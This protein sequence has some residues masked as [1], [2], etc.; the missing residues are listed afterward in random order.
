MD[1]LVPIL[2]DRFQI[3]IGAAVIEIIVPHIEFD[4]RSSQ[5]IEKS[6]NSVQLF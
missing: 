3:A 6:G 4:F 2:D 5:V 1:D